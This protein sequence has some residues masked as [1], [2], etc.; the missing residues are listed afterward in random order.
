[1]SRVVSHPFFVEKTPKSGYT[2]INVLRAY[3]LE[4]KAQ[5]KRQMQGE[6]MKNNTTPTLDYYNQNASSFVLGTIAADMSDARSRFLRELPVGRR[7]LD[8]GCGSGRD[9]KAFLELG[10]QVDAT[11]GSEEVCKKAA[12]LTGLPVKCMLF[13]ELD[14]KEQYDGIWAC[15]SILHLAKPELQEVLLKITDALKHGGILYTSFKY[16]SFE[17]MRNGRYF[18]NFSKK[19]F[20]SFIK[21]I[22]SLKVFEMWITYDVR[23]GREEEK[24]INIL[25][26]RI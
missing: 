18:T 23:P 20:T 8:F 25:A 7:I 12:E 2:I 14:A 10:Y 16:G 5:K 21:T 24:W 1:M 6:N 22:D 9:T 19:S 11:D 13:Q 17:G 15:A 3:D 26:R 4:L